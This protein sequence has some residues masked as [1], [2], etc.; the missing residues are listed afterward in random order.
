MNSAFFARLD[1][2]FV[3]SVSR[4]VTNANISFYPSC[5]IME[6]Y[7]LYSSIGCGLLDQ[8]L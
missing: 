6:P 3:I 1:L 8:I 5:L 7:A 2:A 4:D